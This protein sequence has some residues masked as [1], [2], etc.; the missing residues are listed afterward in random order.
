MELCITVIFPSTKNILLIV[1]F[2]LELLSSM[3]K[4]TYK[5]ISKL[6][7]IKL[8]VR[9]EVFTLLLLLLRTPSKQVGV[10][11]GGQTIKALTRPGPLLPFSSP[12]HHKFYIARMSPLWHDTGRKVVLS[13]I[14]K[15][16]RPTHGPARTP[17]GL[18]LEHHAT[19]SQ[20]GLTV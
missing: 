11:W 3:A 5:T 17:A 13:P 16:M 20:T 14:P 9:T 10:I 6:K 4:E 12:L 15:H 7:A 8:K 2:S 18:S 19:L 1:Y